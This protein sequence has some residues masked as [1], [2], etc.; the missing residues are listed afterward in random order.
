M[1]QIKPGKSNPLRIMD[2]KAGKRNKKT[3]PPRKSREQRRGSKGNDRAKTGMGRE[4][5]AAPPQDMSPKIIPT[6]ARETIARGH[7]GRSGVCTV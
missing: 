1:S 5:A 7:R 3:S 4:N 2:E 6:K